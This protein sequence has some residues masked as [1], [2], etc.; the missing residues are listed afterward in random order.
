MRIKTGLVNPEGAAQGRKLPEGITVRSGQYPIKNSTVPGSVTYCNGLLTND[1]R[2]SYPSGTGSLL[3]GDIV[4]D[5]RFLN[6][7]VYFVSRDATWSGRCWLA[8]HTCIV[9]FS[10]GNW[11]SRLNIW[12]R[13][14]CHAPA[15]NQRVS[16]IAKKWVKQ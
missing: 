9:I 1:L 7:Y 6:E 13:D 16:Q 3:D 10:N 8:A 12:Q 15:M 2:H 14:L 11:S 5:R 4:A